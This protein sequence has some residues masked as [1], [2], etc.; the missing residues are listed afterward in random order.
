VASFELGVLCEVFGLDRSD[1]GLPNYDFAVA[2]LVAGEPLPMSTGGQLLT[3]AHGV[4]RAATAD[5][6]AVT[7]FP[8]D[9]RPPDAYLEALQQA[10]ARGAWVLSVCTGAFA[11]GYAGLLDDRDCTTHWRHAAQL[12]ERFPRA[13]VEPNVLYV[14]DDGIVTSAGTAA[15]IDAC[16]HL[17]RTEQGAAVANGIARRMVVPPHREGGQAQYI[18]VPVPVCTSES[19]APLLDW[20][21]DHLD[22]DL[23]VER[24]AARVH[25]SP[26]TFARRF[27]SEVGTT[28]HKF[29]TAQR[30]AHA[31]LLLESG[32]ESVD[33]IAERVGFGTAAVLR[34]HFARTRQTSPLAYRRAFNRSA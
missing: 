21:M 10:R 24:L 4:E 7:P 30:V 23:S 13:R 25:Q 1:D 34:H 17:V 32:D 9:T 3:P 16:L 22:E 18:S 2:G 19:L 8:H 26:R 29:V 27:R 12:Q 5:L 14:E 31:E 28:P 6:V 15:G 33:R 20:I 11:L